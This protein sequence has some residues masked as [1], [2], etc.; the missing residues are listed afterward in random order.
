MPR[1]PLRIPA[2]IAAL[3]AALAL[4]AC[5]GGEKAD[6]DAPALLDRAFESPASTART[7]TKLDLVLENVPDLPDPVG[8]SLK[9]PYLSNGGMAIPSVDWDASID[10]GGFGTGGQLVSTG[11]DAFAR[12]LTRLQRDHRFGKAGSEHLRAAL[13]MESGLALEPYFRDWVY[14]TALPELRVARRTMV[15]AGTFVTEL[16][17]ATRNLPGPVPLA[18]AVVHGAGR[19]EMTVSLAPAGGTFTIETRARPRRVEVNG[20]AGLLARVVTR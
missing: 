8:L 5:G 17:I 18:I 6:V 10:L 13:E 2:A 9:G 4:S 16:E 11:D 14:G 1:P 19:E 20:G 15:R 7:E 12:A 3:A